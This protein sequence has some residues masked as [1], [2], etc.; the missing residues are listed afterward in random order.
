VTASPVSSHLKLVVR[1]L[2]LIAVLVLLGLVLRSIEQHALLDT[3]WIDR[4]IRNHGLAGLA[5]F[6]AAGSAIVAFGLPRQAVSF[7]GGYAF[8]FLGGTA[9]AFA[10]TIL[11]SALTFLFSRFTARDF[12]S[13]RLPERLRKADAFFGAHPFS[14]TLLIRLLPVGNNGVTNMVAGLSRAAFLPFLGASALGHLPQ[15]VVFAL[16][17]SGINVEPETRITLG[18]VLFIVSVL[19]GVY[20]Y[21]RFRQDAVFS[22]ALGAVVGNG[23]GESPDTDGKD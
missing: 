22:G 15:T 12:V 1:G 20:L 6:L 9:I 10:A 11:G 16:I 8:G 3:E 17:G 7:L 4:E 14:L 19:V 2:I 23:N 18:V 5:I 21:N 13:R